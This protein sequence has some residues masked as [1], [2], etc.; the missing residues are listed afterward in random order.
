MRL[1]ILSNSGLDDMQKLVTDL[2]E[3]VE[4]KDTVVPN[5]G[6]IKSYD[7]KNLCQLYR[8]VPIKDK[9]IL[10][11]YWFLPYSEDEYKT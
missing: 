9:D 6:E 1:C 11:L 4:N 5:L 7:E 2:F 8:F 10:T 3:G